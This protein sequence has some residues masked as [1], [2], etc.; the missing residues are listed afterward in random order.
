MA[1]LTRCQ[2]RVDE[3]LQ[4]P[5]L[6]PGRQAGHFDRVARAHRGAAQ[7]LGRRPAVAAACQQAEGE[8]AEAEPPPAEPG[9]EVKSAMATGRAVPY[10]M[11]SFGSLYKEVRSGCP[12]SFKLRRGLDIPLAGAPEQRMSTR[13]TV[14]SVALVGVDY[15]GLRPALEVRGGRSAFASASACSPTRKCPV[16]AS[17]A[18]GSGEV[19]GINRGQRRM[20]QSVVVRLDGAKTSRRKH[21]RPPAGTAWSRW[22]VALWWTG[23]WSPDCG[24]AFRTRPFS[25]IPAADAEPAAI[26][27]TAMDSN[28]L[29][30]DPALVIRRAAGEF[31]R[32]CRD[33]DDTDPRARCMSVRPR[34]PVARAGARAGR[35]CRVLRAASGRAGRHAHSISSSP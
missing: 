7:G 10:H 5:G 27:V 25:K 13:P 35:C 30:A 2:L 4:L 8:A 6:Q 15:L 22:T 32:W 33:T 16:C 23:C 18:P 1:A 34:R 17:V 9:I 3:G 26:F 20:L 11:I 12:A 21:F 28:P 19:T 31:P 24:P 29:A 14:R